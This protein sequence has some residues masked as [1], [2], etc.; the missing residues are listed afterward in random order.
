MSGIFDRQRNRDRA[1]SREVIGK[2]LTR[3]DQPPIVLPDGRMV[4]PGQVI[5]TARGLTYP[6]TATLLS[7]QALPVDNDRRFLFIQNNDALGLIWVSY[8]VAATLGVGMRFTAGGGGILLDNNV[9]TAA[10]YIIGTIAS[11]P[12]ITIITA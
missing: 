10:I 5:Q 1:L 3:M 8:G 11:N 6:F 2:G 7:Q 4:R 9:P 12:N